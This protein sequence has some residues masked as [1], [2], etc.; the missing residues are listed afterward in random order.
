MQEGAA[1]KHPGPSQLHAKPASVFCLMWAMLAVAG[2]AR[3]PP[4]TMGG[5][6]LVTLLLLAAALSSLLQPAPAQDGL[7]SAWRTGIATNYGG[8]QDGMVRTPSRSR[9]R[10]AARQCFPGPNLPA[11]P[12]G[13]SSGASP[14]MLQQLLLS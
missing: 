12:P 4:R 9:A 10:A 5:P 1:K 2:K 6:R 11:S 3:E 13:G 14:C 8:A 7:P